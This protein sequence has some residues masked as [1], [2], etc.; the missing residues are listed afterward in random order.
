MHHSNII[1]LLYDSN[2]P[3]HKSI[4]KLH[5][6]CKK[7]SIVVNKLYAISPNN[8]FTDVLVEVLSAI[9]KNIGAD[10]DYKYLPRM[11][12]KDLV[13]CINTYIK[14]TSIPCFLCEPSSKLNFDE[15]LHDWNKINNHQYVSY[16]VYDSLF[17]KLFY[18]HSEVSA[19]NV[20]IT[21]YSSIHK[22]ELISGIDIVNNSPNEFLYVKENQDRFDIYSV[23]IANL[24][25]KKYE[26]IRSMNYDISD[27]VSDNISSDLQWLIMFVKAITYFKLDNFS[28]SKSYCYKCIRLLPD[29]YE[30]YLLLTKI[31]YDNKLYSNAN[32]ILNIYTDRSKK[33]DMID[34]VLYSQIDSSMFALEY[35][36]ILVNDKIDNIETS[37]NIAQNVFNN[38]SHIDNRQII[39]NY[40][41]N[42]LPCIHTDDNIF[43]LE[44]SVLEYKDLYNY[45]FILEDNNIDIYTSISESDTSIIIDENNNSNQIKLDNVSQLSALYSSE[46]SELLI[47]TSI[48]P[49]VIN[50][51]HSSNLSILAQYD[52]P[53]DWKYYN[54]ITK[55]AKYKNLYICLTKHKEDI[56]KEYSMVKLCYIHAKNYLPLAMSD[57]FKVS[58]DI[59][60]DIFIDNHN[61]VI[62]GNN[63]LQV[64]SLDKL[65]MNYNLPIDYPSTINL[66]ITSEFEIDVQFTDYKP[67]TT[68]YNSVVI[69][70]QSPIKKLNY[71]NSLDIIT[72]RTTSFSKIIDKFIYFPT[73][74][75]L[76]TKESDVMFYSDNTD[77]ALKQYLTIYDISYGTHYTT[78]KYIIISYHELENLSNIELSDIITNKTLI[79]CLLSENDISNDISGRYKDDE[80]LNKLFLFNIFKNSDYME[81]IYQKIFCDDQYNIRQPYFDI[82]IDNIF[83]N[84]NIFDTSMHFSKLEKQHNSKIDLALQKDSYKLDLLTRLHTKTENNTL[85]EILKYILY[86]SQDITIFYEVELPALLV[87]MNILGSVYRLEDINTCD[88]LY[89]KCILIVESAKN[90]KKWKNIYDSESLIFII[91]T[92]QIIY[93]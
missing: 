65:Y 49:F 11:S 60:N 28:L 58:L 67:S 66:N 53:S 36:R 3:Y 20:S 85:I 10:I 9:C 31:E 12:A 61:L 80:A 51:L 34:N 48:C 81:F 44:F 88:H 14:K 92:N 43:D 22:S 8:I 77:P 78:S 26:D 64:I 1:L 24:L 70:S 71:D 63:N 2:E 25:F 38:E 68:V 86:Y 57:F 73:E 79:I 29:R 90:I 19:E 59:I 32:K 50:R 45:K 69:G 21:R 30:P 93:T 87:Y 56:T 62:V 35:L 84:N 17:Y 47:I 91:D 89:T 39:L 6:F 46:N 33:K 82:D 16:T 5:D 76:Q 15:S 41:S 52:T 13:G 54:C 55:F 4:L 40:L 83:T 42:Q 7:Q 27:D 23:M 75:Q 72:D 74:I 18:I 37:I